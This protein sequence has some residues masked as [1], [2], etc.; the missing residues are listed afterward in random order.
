MLY[1][2]HV[3]TFTPEGTWASAMARL[4][5]LVDVGITVIQMM[6]VADFPGRWGW[7][8]DGV[9]LYA[10][11]RLYGT[12]DDLRRFVD[13]AHALG[14]GVILDVVYNHLGPDGNYLGDFSRE[15]FTDRYTN[16][17]GSA[18]N[19]EGPSP[20]RAFYLENPAYWVEE[21]HFDG[22]RLDATHEVRDA[23]S[24][25]VLAEQARLARAVAGGRQIYV[26]AE[27]EPQHPAIVRDAQRGGYG[28]DALLNDD[29]HHTA[30]VALTGRRDSV[31]R[32][33]QGVAAGAPVEREVWLPLSGT[34]VR[35]ARR[36]SW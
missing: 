29:Y 5:H 26:V 27:N 13:N 35:L 11:T 16:D 8:Y 20:A 34:V 30:V 23:S 9:N 24:E 33:L 7:G 25:H 22:F 1:E 14:I 3:G 6:P 2:L 12:P 10:P 17:W 18:P 15:Y 4:P 28:L 21:F 19:F 32:Q 36:A 31:L